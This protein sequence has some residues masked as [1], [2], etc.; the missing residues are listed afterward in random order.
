VTTPPPR[1]VSITPSDAA[2]L[3]VPSAALKRGVIVHRLMQS[4]PDLPPERRAAAARDYLARSAP[5]LPASEREEIAARALA[6]CDDARFAPLI[7]PGSRAEV[8]IVGRVACGGST[9]TVSGQVDRLAVSA[10]TVWIADYKSNRP[11][12]TRI[13]DVPNGYV[14]QLTLYRAV[15]ARL[16]PGRTIR[17]AL[18]WT[19]VPDFMEIPAAALDAALA[20]VTAA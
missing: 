16:Y 4:L 7:A 14:R 5:K 6:L 2:P 11:A 13:A 15:L 8:P 18:I 17:T 19:D 12:P 9:V 10:D 1:D 20:S 3:A